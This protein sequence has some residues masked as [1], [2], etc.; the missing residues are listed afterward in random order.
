MNHERKLFGTDGIRGVA[1]VHPMTSDVALALGRAVAVVFRREARRHKILIGKDTRLS[2]YMI[3]Q[4]MASGIS[5]MGVDV[6]LVGPVPTPGI[7]FLTRSL[8]ADA[9]AVISAS[10]NPFQDNGI[11]FFAPDGFK[12]PDEVELEIERVMDNLGSGEARP[13]ATD[14]GKAYRI[15]DALGRYNVFLKNTFPRNLTLD[16][17]RIAIDCANGAG[18]KV[19]PEVLDELGATVFALGAEPNGENINESCGAMHPEA[20]CRAVKEFGCH[21]GLALDGDADRAVLVDETGEVVDGD[22][23]L[24]LAAS[25]MIAAGTLRQKTLVTTVM[26]NVGL[27]KALA[28]R[29]GRVVRTPVGDR[30][31]VEEMRRGGY[32][33]GGE[34]SGHIIFLDETTTGDGLVTALYVF[35]RMAESGRPLSELRRAMRRFPQVLLNLKVK[36]R[37]EFGDMPAVARAIESAEKGLGDAGR[38]LVRYS[39]TEAVA[40]VMVEGE[41][42]DEIRRFAQ[43]IVA[44]LDGEIGAR[45]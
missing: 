43:D 15:E 5:S 24:A 25:E 39:G 21:A 38:V 29:G 9:G 6:L 41:N 17:F 28:E 44:A 14:I 26:S 42:D 12:L 11:K 4:A 33:V 19:G 3:E 30:Y 16:G 7:A 13:T 22:E 8:R 23:I 18:Y 32:N 10:H 31:V 34:Q 40:R 2:G 20:L 45:E 27:D 35:A 36:E 1:N 37:R